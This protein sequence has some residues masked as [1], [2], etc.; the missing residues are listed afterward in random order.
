MSRY[1]SPLRCS[2]TCSNLSLT[3]TLLK[4]SF[5]CLMALST[6]YACSLVLTTMEPRYTS[7]SMR[8]CIL[9]LHVLEIALWNGLGPGAKNAPSPTC[10]L[11]TTC[12]IQAASASCEALASS[13]S[14]PTASPMVLEPA[15]SSRGCEIVGLPPAACSF[16][17]R[18]ALLFSLQPAVLR[19]SVSSSSNP[20]STPMSS[21]PW[22]APILRVRGFGPT[23]ASMPWSPRFLNILNEPD[24]GPLGWRLIEADVGPLGER[25][26]E[27]NF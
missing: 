9:F 23:S 12:F 26:T 21:S 2:L 16:T 1:P 3:W 19:F 8:T 11:P 25:L 24:V 27:S 4:R 17:V 13:K 6:L 7:V 18:S 10:M 20:R 22:F 15:K 14:F 5:P